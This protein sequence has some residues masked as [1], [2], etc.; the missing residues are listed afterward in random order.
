MVRGLQYPTAGY[1]CRDARLLVE[2]AMMYAFSRGHIDGEGEGA[3]G[4]AFD[5]PLPGE[6]EGG[7]INDAALILGGLIQ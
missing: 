6:G 7:C 4:H 5:S 1:C 3:C 2:I